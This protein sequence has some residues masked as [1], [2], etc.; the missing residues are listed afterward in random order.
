MADSSHDNNITVRQ[1]DA[2]ITRLIVMV[3]GITAKVQSIPQIETDIALMKNSYADVC[4]DVTKL[5]LLIN[6]NGHPGMKDDV[7]HLKTRVGAICKGI[8]W[9]TAIIGGSL[10][11][12]TVSLWF[13]LVRIYGQFITP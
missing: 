9:A 12:A 7:S 6:G 2:Q 10:L 8:V 13:Y 3:E 1:A 11:A 5:D 4:K